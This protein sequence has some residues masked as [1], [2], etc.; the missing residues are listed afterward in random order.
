MV[1]HRRQHQK[2][3]NIV[4]AGFEK[5]SP[6]E[7]C[8]QAG[9]LHSA[10]QTHYHCKKCQICRSR[11]LAN[12]GSQIQALERLIQTSLKASVITTIIWTLFAFWTTSALSE[13]SERTP[14]PDTHARQLRKSRQRQ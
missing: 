12:G 10:K 8:T 14:G 1:A 9:C 13:R 11:T 3:D 5:F 7:Y 4:A 6:N 2:L